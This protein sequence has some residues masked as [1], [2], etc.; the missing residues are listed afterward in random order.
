MLYC[1]AKPIA[2]SSKNLRQASG[3]A[4]P[5]APSGCDSVLRV[6][7]MARW[8]RVDRGF[9][10]PPFRAKGR[11]IRRANEGI[12]GLSDGI[13]AASGAL[14]LVRRH[15]H[16]P[17]GR[18]CSGAARRRNRRRSGRRPRYRSR[19]Q[20]RHHL[21]RYQSA[22]GAELHSPARDGPRRNPHWNSLRSFGMARSRRP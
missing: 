9:C 14:S 8:V 3:I 19:G 16:V 21:C 10:D 12:H 15:W 6:P 5:S 17:D 1:Y 2:Q 4:H 11:Q 13:C 20:G 22:R 18:S 7:A